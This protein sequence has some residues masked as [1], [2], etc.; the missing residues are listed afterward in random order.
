M[1]ER[2][3]KYRLYTEQIIHVGGNSCG[4]INI[5]IINSNSGK[6]LRCHHVYKGINI[7]N[8]FHIL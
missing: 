1:D 8:L 2:L 5:S 6:Q 4:G 7:E 3:K